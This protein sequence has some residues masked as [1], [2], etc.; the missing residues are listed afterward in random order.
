MNKKEKILQDMVF[1]KGMIQGA[2]LTQMDGDRNSNGQYFEVLTDN[3]DKLIKDF[4]EF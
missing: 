3:L 4:E 1:I 2:W